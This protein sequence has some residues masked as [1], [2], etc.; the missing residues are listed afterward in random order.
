MTAIHTWFK[1]C[2]PVVFLMAGGVAHA[3]DSSDGP[4]RPA[5]LGLCTACHG[6]NGVGT[7]AGAP[8]L[9]GQRRGYLVQ[10]LSNYRDGSRSGGPMN[11][12]AG[13]LSDA[14]IEALADWY[15]AQGEC[16]RTG[17]GGRGRGR[18]R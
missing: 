3:E 15:A 2:I 6:E 7:A 4:E 14:D 18:M 5:R 12:L 16:G 13:S 10:Q 1:C 9:G 11:A 8:N 17:P